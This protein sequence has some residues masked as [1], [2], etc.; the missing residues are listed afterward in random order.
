MSSSSFNGESGDDD[1]D[2]VSGDDVSGDDVSGDDVSGDADHHQHPRDSCWD[3]QQDPPKVNFGV[4]NIP[5]PVP[6]LIPKLPL[7]LPLPL[8]PLFV[9][10]IIV[11]LGS[12]DPII[13]TRLGVTVCSFLAEV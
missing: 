5:V 2:D 3:P 6:V 4:A 13:L 8:P 11:L 9:Y 10:K 12:N 1:G 7:P